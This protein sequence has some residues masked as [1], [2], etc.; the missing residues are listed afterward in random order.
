MC[1]YH[2]ACNVTDDWLYLQAN[3]CKDKEHFSCI[4]LN[5]ESCKEKRNE[6]DV[7]AL[8]HV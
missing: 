8:S 3:F 6:Y 4:M 7:N 5:K 1:R 2:S